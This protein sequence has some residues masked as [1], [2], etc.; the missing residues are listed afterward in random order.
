MRGWPRALACSAFL[1]LLGGCAA[2]YGPCTIDREGG[3]AWC[4]P[5]GA[6][7]LMPGATILDVRLGEDSRLNS[8]HQ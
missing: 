1:G 7:I 3:R 8:N 4:D 5:G 6:M 2:I